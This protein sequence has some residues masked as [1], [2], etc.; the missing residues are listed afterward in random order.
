MSD[1]VKAV[2]ADAGA[3]GRSGLSRRAALKAGVAV[4][5]GAAAWS[6]VSITS[7]GG[8][9]AYANGCTGTITFLLSAP[10]R[11]TDNASTCDG[12][13]LRWHEL[14]P[15]L[16]DNFS[17]DNP[18]PN[19]GT[20]CEDE[21]T[22]FLNFPEGLTCAVNIK[23][24]EKN[25][26]GPGDDLVFEINFGP[27]SA[28]EM[29]PGPGELA[30]NFRCPLVTEYTAGH[31]DEFPDVPPDSFYTITASCITTGADPSCFDQ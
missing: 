13:I 1:D 16:P 17:I 24:F 9:P 19:S 6:G 4:G 22:A 29:P 2:E 3:D 18:I 12:K 5:V 23:L 26:C 21:H 7:L 10:C 8:T 28:P 20:C 15:Q 11:N 30:M 27:S 25:A 14:E 31:V